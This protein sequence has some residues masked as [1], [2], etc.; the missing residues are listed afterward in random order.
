[1]VWNQMVKLCACAP[2]SD[3]LICHGA[4]AINLK[5]KKQPH[6]VAEPMVWRIKGY[7]AV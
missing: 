4:W 6:M 1:M 3:K 2:I 5:L 7:E